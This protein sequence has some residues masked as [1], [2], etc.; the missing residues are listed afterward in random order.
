MTKTNA[1]RM[2]D[3]AAAAYD[4]VE[5]PV[6]ESDLSGEH[7]AETMGENP[8]RVFKTLVAKGDKTGYCV[9]CIPVC[10]QLHLKRCAEISGNK[11]IMMLPLKDLLPVTGYQRGGC[12]PI[13][14]KK[15]FL[16]FIDQSALQYDSI[17]LSA[18]RRGLQLL[19]AP[20]TV[21]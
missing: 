15:Q 2:L 18:G 16:T 17:Y 8:Y 11:K 10:A 1:M 13:G 20:Q 19:I 21:A 12:S 6:D 5:Y 4:I 14:M 3:K 9:F 7:V